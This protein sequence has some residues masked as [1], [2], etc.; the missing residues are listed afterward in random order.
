MSAWS[1]GRL[2]PFRRT[3]TSQPIRSCI[4]A[5]ASS[6]KVVHVWSGWTYCTEGKLLVVLQRGQRLR[7]GGDALGEEQGGEREVRLCC[8]P[9]V[10]CTVVEAV[11]SAG[12]L[13]VAYSRCCPEFASGAVMA[14]GT[15]KTGSGCSGRGTKASA[16][17]LLVG[18][19]PWRWLH[20][21]EC[22]AP[23]SWR[24]AKQRSIGLQGLPFAEEAPLRRLLHD[25]S[26]TT[27]RLDL[28]ES[29]KIRFVIGDF[30]TKCNAKICL[31]TANT[32]GLAVKG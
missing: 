18:I 7:E 20:S 12:L 2:Y 26:T 3:P 28:E 16:A 4:L 22:V 6:A 19:L 21:A 17:R 23:M 24:R 27:P 25:A 32:L 1:T 5:T 13:T 29:S 9:G 15:L 11:R 31:P 30:A 10:F 8:H 14:K